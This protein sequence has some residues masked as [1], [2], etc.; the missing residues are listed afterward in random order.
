M[1]EYDI[2]FSL[3]PKYNKE[4]TELFYYSPSTAIY[5]IKFKSILFQITENQQPSINQFISQ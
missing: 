3:A 1:K 2:P 4:F 5:E